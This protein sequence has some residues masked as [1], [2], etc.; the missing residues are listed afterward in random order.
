MKR[1]SLLLHLEESTTYPTWIYSIVW[2]LIC[3]KINFNITVPST[4][5]FP[6]WPVPFNTFCPKFYLH[7]VRVTSPHH[8]IIFK[9][10]IM[11]V[12][13]EEYEAHYCELYSSLQL[14]FYSWS[15]YS[16]EVDFPQ[17]SSMI[18]Q[19]KHLLISAENLF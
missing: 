9:L 5:M 11:T 10:V 3:F 18:E 2:H 4:L 1:G 6:K 16:Y 7:H 13:D 17:K 19:L 12:C 14:F 15:T 8:H